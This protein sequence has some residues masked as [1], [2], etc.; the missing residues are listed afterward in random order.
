MWLGRTE[1][2]FA[3]KD[4]KTETWVVDKRALEGIRLLR[5][6]FTPRAEKAWRTL[7]DSARVLVG[8][9]D[10]MSLPGLDRAEKQ[11]PPAPTDD[12]LAKTFAVEAQQKIGSQLLHA[13]AEE[14][15]FL[16]LGQRYVFDSHVLSAVTYGALQSYRM[17]PTPLDVGAAVFGN[18]AAS[19]L[20][21][22]EL[23]KNPEYAA[24]LDKIAKAGA[25]FGPDLWQTSVYHLWLSAIRELSPS[26]DADKGLP[27]VMQSDAWSRRMLAT[28]LASWAEL[29][30]DNLL[31]AKQSF[32]AIAGCEYPDAYVDPYPA[33]YAAMGRLGE[34]GIGVVDALPL[35][36]E[37]ATR[38]RAYFTH[39]R[40]TATQLREIAERER[41]GE[42]LTSTQLDFMNHMVS[43][44]GRHG[45]C[46]V[47]LEAH[48][49]YADLHYHRDG[50]LH[51]K[52]TIADV[53]TQPTDATGNVVGKVLHVATGRPRL[54]SVFL[55]G[56][57]GG[58]CTP[59]E[60]RGFVSSY[61]E[62]ITAGFQRLSDEEW[63]A[64]IGKNVDGKYVTS[65]PLDV[66]WL[67]ELVAPGP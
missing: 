34:K 29:R 31:Y 8:P 48:G 13:G 7:D 66:P 20:L 22:P 38:V 19:R 17:M 61:D 37:R 56:S 30:H 15:S 41:R 40:D 60:Y 2:R 36:P 9:P 50:A 43:I 1:L 14:L 16:L 26:A 33:F 65:T 32:T 67:A 63:V 18:P 25:A 27:P 49:W 42:P 28:Q 64:K 35:A 24:A 11:L 39:L 23:A 58:T 45:G 53:H 6:S 21:G 62:V 10:S 3:K 12:A 54:F 59:R 5:A 51:A 47:V 55:P 52:P 57:S 46:T 4:P 44:D